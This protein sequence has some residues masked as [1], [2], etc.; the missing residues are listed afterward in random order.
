MVERHRQADAVS[1]SVLKLLAD[2]EAIVQ[3]VVMRQ[4]RALWPARGA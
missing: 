2:E 1:G 3:D 4:R